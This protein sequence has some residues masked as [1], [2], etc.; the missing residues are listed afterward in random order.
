MHTRLSGCAQ[1]TSQ[2][3][4]GTGC[5]HCSPHLV[6]VDG[7][8]EKH[9]ALVLAHRLRSSHGRRQQYGDMLCHAHADST[10]HEP[11]R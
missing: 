9:A 2:A 11:S 7:R 8:D 4:I 1:L 5:S 3:I 6:P 10:R